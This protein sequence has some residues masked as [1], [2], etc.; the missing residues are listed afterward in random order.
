MEATLFRSCAT[1]LYAT[2]IFYGIDD[3]EKDIY[4]LT[5]EGKC[6][7][8]GEI[9]DLENNQNLKEE[10]RPSEMLAIADHWLREELEQADKSKR[11]LSH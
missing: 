5:Y 1:I 9:Q 11:E 3:W 10:N 7:W 4:Y 6:G 8:Q 2:H